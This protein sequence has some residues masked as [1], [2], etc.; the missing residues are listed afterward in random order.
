MDGKIFLKSQ[1]SL[2][3]FSDLLLDLYPKSSFNLF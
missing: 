1:I 3:Y 2:F